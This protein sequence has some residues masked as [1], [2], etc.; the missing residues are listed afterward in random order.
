[1]SQEFAAT[2]EIDSALD[3]ELYAH[4]MQS[5]I[6]ALEN[7]LEYLEH[8]IDENIT[9]QQPEETF[10]IEMGEISVMEEENKALEATCRNLKQENTDLREKHAETEQR[11]E[12]M[13]AQVDALIKRISELI[14]A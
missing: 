3:P 14:E 2:I 4:S 1:M 8:A 10:A 12:A 6:E 9:R 11:I 13:S 7:A 5:T